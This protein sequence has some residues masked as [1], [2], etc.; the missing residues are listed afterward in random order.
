M[1]YGQIF[2]V[3]PH[4]SRLGF[5]PSKKKKKKKKNTIGGLCLKFITNLLI[6][7]NSYEVGMV[8]VDNRV[9]PNC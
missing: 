5:R 3:S 8:K 1:V 7:R 9:S 4:S 6:V 2:P